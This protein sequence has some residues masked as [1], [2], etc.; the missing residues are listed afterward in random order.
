MSLPE[1]DLDTTAVRGVA[2]AGVYQRQERDPPGTG[3]AERKQSYA[4]RVSGREDI[5]FRRS[6]GMRRPY[7]NTPA[8]RRVKTNGSAQPRAAIFSPFKPILATHATKPFA[9]PVHS[10]LAVS[11]ATDTCL[12]K[13]PI[14]SRR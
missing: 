1:A 14:S 4:S 12:R 7:G 3:V 5:L 10:I 13:R 2:S 11:V 6:T 8:T 9:L